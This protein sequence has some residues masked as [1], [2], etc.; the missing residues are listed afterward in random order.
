[1]TNPTGTTPPTGQP[2]ST[3]STNPSQP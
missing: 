3:P 2:P 1:V